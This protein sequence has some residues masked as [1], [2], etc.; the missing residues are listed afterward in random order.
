MMGWDFSGGGRGVGFK[1]QAGLRL[2]RKEGGEEKQGY[3]YLLKNIREN[4]IK[5]RLI[6]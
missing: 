5:Y 2:L 4:H 3:L 1:G 6:R